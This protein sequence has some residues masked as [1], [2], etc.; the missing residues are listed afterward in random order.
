MNSAIPKLTVLIFTAFV[1]WLGLM[2]LH[3]DQTHK[4]YKAYQCS[5][6]K[7]WFHKACL[8]KV[9][10]AL[11]KHNAEFVCSRCTIPS[12][13]HSMESQRIY[14]HLQLFD[15]ANSTQNSYQ[16][17]VIVTWKVP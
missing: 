16:I 13:N 7:D 3:P 10:I 12:C 15:P 2:D 17:W 11:L 1:S 6:C 5:N 8:L 4:K 9:D 14:K